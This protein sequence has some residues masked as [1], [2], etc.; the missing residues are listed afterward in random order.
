MTLDSTQHQG[1]ADWPPTRNLRKA[2]GNH[3]STVP[4]YH[5]RSG[6]E[7]RAFEGNNSIYLETKR[8][9]CIYLW[10][11][12]YWIA[13]K[14]WDLIL[15]LNTTIVHQTIRIPNS[16]LVKL[17]LSCFP[18]SNSCYRLSSFLG[19]LAVRHVR[20]SVRKSYYQAAIWQQDNTPFLAYR[21]GAEN[22]KS[23][24]HSS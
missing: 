17:E 15:S 9:E 13:L 18:H 2:T 20:G 12:P 11:Q 7:K 3:L 21:D 23:G 5:N 1:G 10:L 22:R 24:E 19:D 6:H 16:K 8:T 14:P 4:W